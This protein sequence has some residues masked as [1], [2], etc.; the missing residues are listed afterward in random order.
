MNQLR[1]ILLGFVLISG[2]VFTPYSFAETTDYS[3]GPYSSFFKLLQYLF[4]SGDVTIITNSN[5]ILD[6]DKAV[7][8]LASST[9]TDPTDDE[10]DDETEDEDDKTKHNDKTKSNKSKYK[11]DD[12][13]KFHHGTVH[14]SSDTS[15]EKVTL[16]HVPPGNHD[17]AHSITVSGLSV[18]AHLDHGDYLGACD[19]SET[20]KSIDQKHNESDHKDKKESKSKDN[21]KDG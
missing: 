11:T 5:S 9:S 13:E 20:T 2:S 15:T 4:S 19:D 21:H 3:N 10:T 12:I 7:I 6:F 8:V 16:C 17:K 1:G 18:L 14:V